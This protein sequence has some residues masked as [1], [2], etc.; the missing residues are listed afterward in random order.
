MH[1]DCTPDVCINVR[2]MKG[3]K[4][5]EENQSGVSPVSGG[6]EVNPQPEGIVRNVVRN[7][8]RNIRFNFYAKATN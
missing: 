4:T 1:C 5:I 7:V 2:S 8:V 3:C 6:T